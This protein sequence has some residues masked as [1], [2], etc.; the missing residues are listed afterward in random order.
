M[1]EFNK[2]DGNRY[3]DP[4]SQTSFEVDHIA[5]VGGIDQDWNR[6]GRLTLNSRLLLGLNHTHW[7]HKTPT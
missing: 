5:Q 6:A 1:S 2:L 7:N 4:E 3:F